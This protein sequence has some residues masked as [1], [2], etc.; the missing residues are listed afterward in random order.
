[1][2]ARSVVLALALLDR[3]P[4]IAIQPGAHT[5]ARARV[6]SSGCSCYLLGQRWLI[7]YF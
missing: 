1:V 7:G 6:L 3:Q 4:L 5:Q 2:G